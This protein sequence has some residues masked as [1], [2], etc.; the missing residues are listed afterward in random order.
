MFLLLFH[1]SGAFTVSP[2]RRASPFSS[3][4]P[5]RSS[6]AEGD[7]ISRSLSEDCGLLALDENSAAVTK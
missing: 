1:I 4:V 3:Q 2:E 6:A 5:F 7:D